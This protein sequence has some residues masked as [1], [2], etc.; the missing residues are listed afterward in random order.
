LKNGQARKRE[1]REWVIV[2][3][4]ASQYTNAEDFAPQR[5]DWSKHYSAEGGRHR[6]EDAMQ[7]LTE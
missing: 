5:V 1:Q 7:G 4:A 6:D 3:R 2:E